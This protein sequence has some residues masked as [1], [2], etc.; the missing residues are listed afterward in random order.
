MTA[1]EAAVEEGAD[2]ARV[3]VKGAECHEHKVESH[4]DQH[5]CVE[6][7]GRGPIRAE[8]AAIVFL[9]VLIIFQLDLDR[10]QRVYIRIYDKIGYKTRVIGFRQAFNLRKVFVDLASIARTERVDSAKDDEDKCAHAEQNAEAIFTLLRLLLVHAGLATFTAVLRH[11]H[12]HFFFLAA[13]FSVTE[14]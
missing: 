8:N 13:H 12:L 11:V 6:L 2:E 3:E 14:I 5:N 10:V 1:A 9:A 4:E 7:E